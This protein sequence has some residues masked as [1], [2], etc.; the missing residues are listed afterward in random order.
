ME[1]AEC[2]GMRELF[3]KSA[4]RSAGSVRRVGGI[5]VRAFGSPVARRTDGPCLREASAT[6][7]VLGDGMLN[8][9]RRL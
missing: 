8:D 5:M 7:L 3:G 4:A 1:S 2:E 9:P 6:E